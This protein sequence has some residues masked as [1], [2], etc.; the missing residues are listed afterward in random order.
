MVHLEEDPHCFDMVRVARNHR[1]RRVADAVEWLWRIKA[2]QMREE[3]IHL[4]HIT[5][6]NKA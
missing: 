4:W 2:R 5:R 6:H 1:Q 3:L